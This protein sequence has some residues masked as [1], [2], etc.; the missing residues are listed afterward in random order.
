VQPAVTRIELPGVPLYSSGKVRETFDL[1]DRLLM[2]ATDRVSTFDVVLPTGIPARGIILTQFSRFWFERLAGV[3]P[4]HLITTRLDKAPPHVK[5]YLHLL[6]DRT[7]VT[8]KAQR[9]DIEC[10]VRGYI[11]GNAWI[12][13]QQSG[14]YCGHTFPAGLRESDKLPEP[15]FTPTTKASSGHDEP[16][17]YEQ[18]EN[19]VGSDVAAQL[20]DRSMEL[21]AIAEAHALERDIILADTKFE[22]GFINGELTLIDEIFTP[23]SSRYWDAQRY[24]PGKA[25]PSFDKQILRDWLVKSGWDKEPPAPKLPVEIA[26]LASRK[27]YEVFQRLTG[28]TLDI[29]LSDDEES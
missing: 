3:M 15:L 13:Y 1:G 22:F 23:D 26:L 20:R 28:E 9:I 8:R 5:P 2:V 11:S 18:V 4:N 19:F 17:S 29:D 25:Q 6:R 24:A 16:I 21:Y 10:V 7:M 14:S 27:Y 12:A